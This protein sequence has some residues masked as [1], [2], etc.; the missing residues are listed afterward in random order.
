VDNG[1]KEMSPA[2]NETRDIAL[3][4]VDGGNIPHYPLLIQSA[5]DE[6]MPTLRSLLSDA[7]ELACLGVFAVAVALWSMGA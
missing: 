5:L 2:S 4:S 1:E 7:C 3:I 6:P